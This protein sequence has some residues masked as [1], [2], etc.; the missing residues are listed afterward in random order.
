MLSWMLYDQSFRTKNNL[1]LWCLS[2]WCNPLNKTNGHSNYDWLIESEWIKERTV[3]YLVSYIWLGKY[4]NQVAN[5]KYDHILWLRFWKS[6]AN[7]AGLDFMWGK[8]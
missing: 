1:I 3:M 4:E 8:F 6:S 7:A 2:H 5:S